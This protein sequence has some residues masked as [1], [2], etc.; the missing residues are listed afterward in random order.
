MANRLSSNHRPAL[1]AIGAALLAITATAC[2]P[3]ALPASFPT[4]SPASPAAAAAPPAPVGA[5]LAEGPPL[6]G[7]PA[8]RW[9]G[10]SDDARAIPKEP[11]TADAAVRLALRDNRALRASLQEIGVARGELDQAGLPPNPTVSIDLRRTQT[12][13]ESIRAGFAVEYDLTRAILVPQRADAARA[14]LEAARHR[15]AA[16]VVTTGYEARAA[17]FA[18][19][20]AAA[21][22]AVGVRVL[23]AFAAGRDAARALF[24]AGNIPEL[25]VTTQEAAY[26]DARVT[27]AQL[28]LEELDRREA[29]NRLLGLH[30]EQT[31]WPLAGAL[32]PAPDRLDLPADLEQAAIRSS[33]TLAE[34]KSRLEATAR[35]AG[36]ARTEG[37][38]PDVSLTV[39]ADHDGPAWTIGGGARF[40]LPLFDRKQGTVA[41]RAAEFD[42]QI[43]RYQGAA[44]DIRSA[45]REARN[46]VV[47]THARARHYQE[48]VVPARRR[49]LEQALLQYNGMQIGVFQLLAARRD[50]L[51]AE[52]AS[53]DALRDFWTARAALDA[54]LAGQRVGVSTPTAS[55]SLGSSTSDASGGH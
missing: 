2:A 3:R 52:L 22:H 5:A 20:A 43:E 32:P 30:G 33:L 51:G 19:Q 10:L 25:D 36:L 16:A 27:V 15:A 11:L 44:V 46:R 7:E 40:T 37:W 31:S 6:P 13:G 53:I 26:E 54:L 12:A 14:D 55:P 4:T 8:A 42:A 35:R 39:N 23:D 9:P 34:M 28:E 49:V 45:A 24:A 18:L 38:L 29:L 48:V 17:F 41:A 47:S 50:Q 21:R 1:A